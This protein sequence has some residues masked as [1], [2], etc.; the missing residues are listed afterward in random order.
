MKS[1]KKIAIV[2]V[3]IVLTVVLLRLA[4][5][6]A[7]ERGINYAIEKTDG[8]R[9]QVGDVDIALFRGAYQVQDIELFAV[10]NYSQQPTI[11]IKQLDIS[12]LW[13][14]LFRGS[15]VA[16]MQFLEPEI[17]YADKRDSTEKID[18]NLKDEQT[19]ISLTNQLVPFAIDRIDI[20]DGRLALATIMNGETNVNEITKVNGLISN[21]TNS[22]DHS[23]SLV[24]NMQIDALIEDVS[25]LAL[26]GSYDPYAAKPTFNI[27]AEMQ[28]LPVK[29]LDKLIQFYAPFDVEAGQ[30]DFALKI[31]AVEGK[32]DGYV[33]AGVYDLSVFSWHEDVERDGD[34][35]FQ[36]LFESLTGGLA[37]IFEDDDRDL[38]ATEVPLSGQIDDI[39]TPLWPAIYS[40]VR[41]AFI[42]SLDIKVDDVEVQD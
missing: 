27:G 12:L 35:P 9:G 33:K 13:S 4:A 39:E 20:V 17:Y 26:T 25:S 16:E 11:K 29:N 28:R 1:N 37:G 40:I 5:P 6:F 42:E 31:D 7:L 21:I 34:N 41:N 30:L 14:A 2:A 22:K 15:V 3:C 23:G 18:E 24:T 10:E 36:W 19:W 8:L 32:V 38:L